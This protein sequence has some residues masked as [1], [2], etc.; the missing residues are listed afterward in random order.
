MGLPRPAPPLLIRLA[1]TDDS[2]RIAQWSRD[3]IETGL[4]WRWTA[5]RVA[6]AVAAAGTCTIVAESGA[7]R[8]GFAIMEFRDEHAHLSLL[9]VD[10]EYQAQGIGRALVGWLEASAR[11]AGIGTV[12]LEVRA[13]NAIARRFYAGLGYRELFLMPGYYAGRE[14]ALRLVHDVRRLT[15][16]STG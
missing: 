15:P 9:A 14:A 7:I 4:G 8:T 11:T 12:A 5:R 16:Q 3:L 1:R 6:G 10:P 13:T 2:P